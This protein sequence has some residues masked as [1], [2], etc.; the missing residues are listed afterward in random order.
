MLFKYDETKEIFDV[1]NDIN[2]KLELAKDKAQA[3]LMSID[4]SPEEIE[5]IDE[6][7]DLYYK[8]SNKY[9]K[10]EEEMLAF[11]ENAKQKRNSIL[12]ADEELDRLNKEYDGLLNETVSLAEKLSSERKK[13]AS[14]FEKNVKNELLFLD[15]PKMQFLLISI[16]VIYRQQVLTK[17]NL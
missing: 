9:G 3:L 16:K 7:L 11:L 1:F 15:M 4:F 10:N 5:M 14:D 12:F 2:D 13:V 8:F 6:R 17:L